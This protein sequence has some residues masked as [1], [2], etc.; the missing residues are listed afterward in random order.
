M[1]ITQ[2]TGEQIVRVAGGIATHVGIYAASDIDLDVTRNTPNSN[3]EEAL[4][5]VNAL[6]A[7]ANINS[8]TTDQELHATLA[9][10]WYSWI[11]Y[12][13]MSRQSASCP[14]ECRDPASYQEKK[15]RAHSELCR[16]LQAIGLTD[17][18]YCSS[19]NPSK[20]LKAFSATTIKF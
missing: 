20:G 17:P 5:W 10:R 9:M 8:P 12:W 13:R 11:Y 3:P 7:A 14:D 2:A 4:I 16:H 1:A 18:D 19:I 15:N 6:L